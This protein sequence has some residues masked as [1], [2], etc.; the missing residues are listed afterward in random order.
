MYGQIKEPEIFPPEKI[1][2]GKDE[3]GNLEVYYIP[4]VRKGWWVRYYAYTGG[5]IGNNRHREYGVGR[6]IG[7]WFYDFYIVDV[8]S[9]D[10]AKRIPIFLP[11]RNGY[12]R[13]S[14]MDHD[15]LWRIEEPVMV[16]E[17]VGL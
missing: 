12:A 17:G 13:K 4:T 7:G 11:D 8:W 14:G 15:R 3:D 2:Q 9:F 1:T 10:L 16:Q 5:P 6:V